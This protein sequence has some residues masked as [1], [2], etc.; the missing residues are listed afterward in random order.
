MTDNSGRNLWSLVGLQ[1]GLGFNHR[2]ARLRPFGI[3][4]PK[5]SD[6]RTRSGGVCG[7]RQEEEFLVDIRTGEYSKVPTYLY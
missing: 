1:K 4:C 3:S 6:D 7:V 2:G 5:I